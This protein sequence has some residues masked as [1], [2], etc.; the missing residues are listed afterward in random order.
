MHEVEATPV[1]VV[2]ALQS[3]E[4]TTIKNEI[5]TIVE[6]EQRDVEE[7]REREVQTK[8]KR[9]HQ[10]LPIENEFGMDVFTMIEME[11]T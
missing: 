6:T 5:A 9:G 8:T 7:R 2:L 10:F 4:A 3:L 11:A 1:V